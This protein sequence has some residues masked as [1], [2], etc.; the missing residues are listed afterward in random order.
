MEDEAPR[1]QG[2]CVDEGGIAPT[3]EQ[4]LPQ[5]RTLDLFFFAHLPRRQRTTVSVNWYGLL[6]DGRALLLAPQRCGMPFKLLTHE[7]KKSVLRFFLRAS[8]RLVPLFLSHPLPSLPPSSPPSSRLLPCS[9]LH[10]FLRCFLISFSVLS[11]T[12]TTSFVCTS[13]SP[14]K[15]KKR[16]SSRVQAQMNNTTQHNRKKN[17]TK[18]KANSKEE[19]PRCYSVRCPLSLSLSLSL[20]PSLSLPKASPLIFARPF[21]PFPLCGQCSQKKCPIPPSPPPPNHSYKCRTADRRSA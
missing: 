5:S 12:F 1:R 9:A 2:Y 10:F 13:G 4:S 20:S 17:Q 14:F 16:V 18:K 11:S 21:S 19:G 8:H 3:N 7:G 15:T 6:C